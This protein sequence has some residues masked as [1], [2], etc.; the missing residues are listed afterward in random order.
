MVS[1]TV[2]YEEGPCRVDSKPA[3]PSVNVSIPCGGTALQVME[4]AVDYPDPDVGRMYRFAAT[5]FGS[6]LGYFIN[7]INSVP[8]VIEPLTNESCFWL[9]LI[10]TPDGSILPSNVGVSSYTFKVD[11]YGMIMRYSAQNEAI[12]NG[13]T[14]STLG[15]CSGSLSLSSFAMRFTNITIVLVS[16]FVSKIFFLDL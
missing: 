6:T 7:A 4:S 9:F 14:I 12:G 15:V 11:G 5:Y 16:A 13:T 2:R 3:I 1:Y 10:Q 8:P